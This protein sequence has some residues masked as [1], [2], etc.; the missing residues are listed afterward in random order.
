MYFAELRGANRVK[1]FL[2]IITIILCMSNTFAAFA[3]FENAPITDNAGYLTEGEFAELSDQLNEIRETYKVDV[4]V[5]TEY[6]MS[7]EDA[8]STADDIFDYMGYGAGDGADGIILY[9]ATDPRVYHMSTH[10]NGEE[11][12]NDNGLA[13][14]E[15]QFLPSLKEDDYYSAVRQYA[16]SAERLLIM[17]EQGEPYNEAQHSDT[18]VLC[19]IAGALF[20]PLLLAYIMMKQKLAKMKTAVKRD[21]A[22]NY[23]KQGSFKLDSSRDIFLYSTVTKTEKPKESSDSGVGHTSSSGEHHGGRGGSY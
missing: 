4:A 12:F 22:G 9:I 15:S 8:E 6:E 19:V 2:A 14:I 7:G 23:M 16:D 1:K 18:Y 10:G 3:D 17:A 5:F 13:Y 11:I 21:Y 20:L